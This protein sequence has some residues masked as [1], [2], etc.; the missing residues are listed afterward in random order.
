MTHFTESARTE[1][2][3]LLAYERGGLPPLR[4]A[5]ATTHRPWVD[6]LRER[7]ARRC[8]P[9]MLA[10]QAGWFILNDRPL[11]VTWNGG[12][13]PSSP[14]LEWLDGE[15]PGHAVS[16]F[17]HGIVTWRFPYIFRTSPGFD[18]LVRGPANAPK[19][20]ASALEGIVETDWSPATFT[21]NWILTRPGLAVTF[22]PDEPIC[23]I[24]PQRRGDL[25]SFQPDV[26]AIASDP[27]TQRAYRAWRDG[28]TRFQAEL[29]VTG[30]NAHRRHWQRHYAR[31]AFPDGSHAPTGAQQTRLNLCPFQTSGSPEPADLSVLA[32]MDETVETHGCAGG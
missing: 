19:D 2:P 15:S 4:L 1:R 9:L 20:G 3:Q 24:V 18:L 5:P 14:R 7:I 12:D 13:L 21:V 10:N 28:R 8:L 29:R 26:H 23:M 25:A 6:T 16:H 30:S 31:G 17:G 22:E 11:R 32:E 27:P